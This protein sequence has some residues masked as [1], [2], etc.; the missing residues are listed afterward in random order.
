MPLLEPNY[1]G[2]WIGKQTAKGTPN[3]TPTYRPIMVAGDFNIARDDGDENYSDLTKYGARTD[4][5]NSLLGNAEP[6]CEATPAELAY[7]LWLFHGGETVT[8]EASVVGPPV[9]PAMSRHRFTPST[10]LGHPF[11]SFLRVGSSVIRRHQFNDCYIT[12]LAIESSSANKATRVTPRILSLDP[13]AIYAAD[14]AASLPTDRPFLFTDA[15]Q[16]GGAAAATIDGSITIDGVTFRGI[17]QFNVTIDDAWEPI[18]GDAATPFDF[19]QGQPVVNV[20]STVFFNT[21]GHARFNSLVY[22]TPTP[23]TGAKPIRSAV[24]ANGSFKATLRQRDS[25]SAHSGRE[26]VI[27]VPAVKWNVPDAPGPNPDGGVTELALAGTMRPP[28]GG[29]QPYT[30]DVKTAAAVAA[31][32]V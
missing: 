24:A 17:T 19:V 25:A 13:A 6:G 4:W 16:V 15:S 2:W 23:A 30:I 14:P 32:T 7:L 26:L 29:A 28:T 21:D 8:A 5:V 1:Y 12:R 10:T 20:A 31:F 27:D 18:Y 3:L 11:T 22:G 9:V